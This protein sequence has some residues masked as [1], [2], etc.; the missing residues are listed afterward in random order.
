MVREHQSPDV[1]LLIVE[2]K[3]CECVIQFTYNL[4]IS[5]DVL[6]LKDHAC[7]SRVITFCV[8]TFSVKK[9]LTFCVEKLLHF[10]LN[11]L[12]HFASMLLHFA[13]VL[14]FAAIVITF[15]VSITFCGDYYILQH[16]TR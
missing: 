12:L 14:H 16:N 9:V 2:N 15:C 7:H 3:T 8:I 6:I 1:K 5:H 4:S 11:T 13:L 10:L